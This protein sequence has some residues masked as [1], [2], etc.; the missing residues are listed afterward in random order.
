MRD[1]LMN[2]LKGL[3]PEVDFEG[4]DKLI[5]DGILDSFDLVSLLGEIND[6]FDVEVSFD[7]I[8]PENFNSVEAMTALIQRLK[9]EE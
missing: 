3:R 9:E 2:I 6:C 4:E 1:E 5:D 8:E 7:D